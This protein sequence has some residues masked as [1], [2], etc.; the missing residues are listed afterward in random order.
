MQYEDNPLLD[1]LYK[2]QDDLS[3]LYPIYRRVYSHPGLEYNHTDIEIQYENKRTDNSGWVLKDNNSIA[4]AFFHSPYKLPAYHGN[5]TAQNTTNAPN[6]SISKAPCET[7]CNDSSLWVGVDRHCS[8]CSA[9]VDDSQYQRCDHFC[10]AQNLTCVSGYYIFAFRDSCRIKDHDEQQ[11]IG[12]DV[13]LGDRHTEDLICQC[14]TTGQ[15]FS[16]T[17]YPTSF[18]STTFITSAQPTTCCQNKDCKQYDQSCEEKLFD[19]STMECACT[20]LGLFVFIFLLY[21]SNCAPTS[22]NSRRDAARFSRALLGF[23]DFTSDIYLFYYGMQLDSFKNSIIPFIFAVAYCLNLVQAI[24]ILAHTPEPIVLKALLASGFSPFYRDFIRVV[25]PSMREDPRT[26]GEMIFFGATKSFPILMSLGLWMCIHAEKI[27]FSMLVSGFFSWWMVIIGVYIFSQ[28]IAKRRRIQRSFYAPLRAGE[29]DYSHVKVSLSQRTSSSKNRSKLNVKF[30][31]RKV[32]KSKTESTY[33]PKGQS[34]SYKITSLPNQIGSNDSNIITPISPSVDIANHNIKLISN[35]STSQ[36]SPRFQHWIYD[37]DDISIAKQDIIGEGN[38]G[39]VYRGVYR[40][41]EVALKFCD[42]DHYLKEGDLFFK[43]CFHPNVCHFFGIY[44]SESW[45]AHFL[46]MQYFKDGNL[47][48]AMN[49][50]RFTEEQSVRICIQI[51]SGIHHLHCSNIIHGDISARNCLIE[52]STL[53][54]AVTDFGLARRAPVTSHSK[55]LAPR[56]S[57]PEYIQSRVPTFQSDIWALGVTFTEIMSCG[58][59]PYSGLSNDEVVR[60]LI[61]TIAASRKEQRWF[62]PLNLLKD[63]SHRKWM[64]KFA[65]IF[66]AIFVPPESR[67]TAK[68]IVQKWRNGIDSFSMHNTL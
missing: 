8:L 64:S 63:S 44:Q 51:A 49:N 22:P 35:Y 47:V 4:K 62:S 11:I 40:E 2:V 48:Q 14:S 28:H 10:D 33:L 5:F 24:Y 45:N 20:V 59:T 32:D 1:G 52:C 26:A 36:Y 61:R 23:C 13:P 65:E 43:C 39:K 12:C 37:R 21:L 25:D 57:A 34:E 60:K 67:T 38:F 55:S 50:T 54:V 30:T 16:P 66:D 3:P 56:W 6:S 19:M 41:A 7:G 46:V 18:Q 31:P 29:N 27:L 17:V 15:Q 58:C 42:T 53:T 9:K 68:D